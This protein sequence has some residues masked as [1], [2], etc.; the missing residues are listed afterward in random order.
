MSEIAASI[1]FNEDC[2]IGMK[3]FPDG[4]FDLAICDVPYG[5]GVGQMAYLKEIATTVKQKNGTRINGNKQKKV[6]TQK[7]WD[8]MP[9]SQKYFDELRRVSKE[10]IIFGVEYVDWVGLGSGRI[11]WNKGV[12]EGMSFKKY[13]KAYCSLIDDEI[14]LNLLWAGMQQAKGLSE[15]MTQ[16]GNKKLNERRIHPCHKPRLLYKKLIMDYGF[17]GM[18]LLD[19]HLGGGSIR[20]EAD[21]AGCNFTGFEIDK[22]YWEKQENRYSNHKKQLRLWA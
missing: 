6:Y 18:R 15:P 4:Y 5:I 20:I 9:P 13:E 1:V 17:H 11:K 2:E 8:I 19:T 3:K 7:I 16:Q 10:Q 14:E 12:A 21:L 22:E